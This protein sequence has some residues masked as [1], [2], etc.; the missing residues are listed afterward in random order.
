EGD[1]DEV[2][3]ERDEVSPGKDGALLLRLGQRIGGDPRRQR[4]EIVGKIETT[5]DGADDR[6]EDIGD[7]RVD[8]GAE[9]GTDDHTDGEIDDVAAQREFLEFLEHGAHPG[10]PPAQF[11]RPAW[12]MA[13]RTAVL[14]LSATRTIGRRTVSAHLPNTERAYLTGAGLVSTNKA[15]C[16]GISLSCTLSAV[17]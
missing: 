3:G 6:H 8:D 9:G 5:G 16:N 14:V 15:V 2:N 1:D 17:P 7:Q 13:S 10:R 12:T 4:N 11:I